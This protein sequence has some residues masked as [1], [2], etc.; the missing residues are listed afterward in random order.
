MSRFQRLSL[1]AAENSGS[2]Q[3]RS[4]QKARNKSKQSAVLHPRI[5]QQRKGETCSRHNKEFKIFL[6]TSDTGELGVLRKA[7]AW[8]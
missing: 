4:F 3:T 5:T 1:T 2:P 6:D 8:C 7:A